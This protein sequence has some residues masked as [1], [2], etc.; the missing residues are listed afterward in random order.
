MAIVYDDTLLAADWVG[1]A[2]TYFGQHGG[3]VTSKGQFSSENGTVP[4]MEDL[5][6]TALASKPG[7][8]FFMAT[9][10][11]APELEVAFIRTAR[12]V[13]PKFPIAMPN[14]YDEA[15]KA[16][17][18]VTAANGSKSYPALV[19]GIY[20]VNDVIYPK[21]NDRYKSMFGITYMPTLDAGAQSNSYDAMSAIIRAAQAAGYSKLK[22]INKALSSKTF[23]FPRY[24]G[25]TGRNR[26]ANAAANIRLITARLE[27]GL[28]RPEALTRPIHGSGGGGAGRQGGGQRA[29]CTRAAPG[30]AAAA[31]A[32]AAAADADAAVQGGGAYG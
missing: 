20:Y 5:V 17:L 9:S 28:P 26:D 24:G 3:S 13:D 1:L 23:T 18:E 32:A 30:A 16:G 29:P 22:N 6:K 2:E 14:G 27:E 10:A 8:I 7:F 19:D 31:T 11:I 4:Q 12:A 21:A 15:A 25:N